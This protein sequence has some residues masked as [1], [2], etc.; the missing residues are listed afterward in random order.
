M[1]PE[2]NLRFNCVKCSDI[3]AYTSHH[4]NDGKY[5]QCLKCTIS[6]N[7]SNTDRVSAINVC[8]CVQCSL[9]IDP[10]NGFTASGGGIT[11]TNCTNQLKCDHCHKHF[12]ILR[13]CGAANG[14][15]YCSAC[16]GHPFRDGRH[17]LKCNCC[18]QPFP[19][20]SQITVQ[21]GQIACPM[22]TSSINDLNIQ[23]QVIAILERGHYGDPGELCIQN[24]PPKDYTKNNNLVCVHNVKDQNHE[25]VNNVEMS[26]NSNTNKYQVQM[27][28]FSNQVKCC[29]HTTGCPFDTKVFDQCD[30]TETKCK[31]HISN[32]F[33]HQQFGFNPIQQLVPPPTHFTSIKPFNYFKISQILK[34]QKTS[35][36]FGPKFILPTTFNLP[37]WHFFLQ[38]YWDVQL[39]SFLACG[40]P[41]DI[42]SQ[43]EASKEFVNHSSAV[44]YSSHIQHYLDTELKH[45]AILG[46]FSKTPIQ[47]LHL[48]PMM[49][50][51]KQGAVNR[52]VIID[53][54]WPKGKS[55]N[56]NVHPSTYMGTPFLLTFPTTDVITGRIKAL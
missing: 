47:G 49:T 55:V 29:C 11:C 19:I 21:S 15:I 37:L 5:Y 7:F 16:V 35:N 56:D 4:I 6:N 12:N 9:L 43:P 20:T 41:L 13:G 36:S 42:Q 31:Y 18:S 27:V 51:P 24:I 48:S 10:V 40:F 38:H 22:C 2:Y 32:H 46:P 52:R 23:N 14:K 53:L 30:C 39:F 28:N 3:N 50:R 17:M 26:T 54:S 33:I 34:N 8:I 1:L 25:C 44:K 45:S